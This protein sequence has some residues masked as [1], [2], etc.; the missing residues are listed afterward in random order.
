MGSNVVHAFSE[1]GRVLIGVLDDFDALRLIEAS[2]I[3]PKRIEITND[4]IW[5][6]V[7]ISYILLSS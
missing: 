2:D 4:A 6:L 5:E 1:V 7:T 3:V